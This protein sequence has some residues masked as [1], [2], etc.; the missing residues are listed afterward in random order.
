[1]KNELQVPSLDKL[2]GE[3]RRIRHSREQEV[4]PTVESCVG[5]CLEY[6]KNFRDAKKFFKNTTSQVRVKIQELHEDLASR[7]SDTDFYCWFTYRWPIVHSENCS[8]KKGI[9][10]DL[11]TKFQA[12]IISS[13][14]IIGFILLVRYIL[15]IIE[16]I[17]QRSGKK[18]C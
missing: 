7:L 11:I 10:M 13:I 1:M 15:Y 2:I 18:R 14:L 6:E 17:S 12:L 9:I 4:A 5:S 3:A 8:I 16:S